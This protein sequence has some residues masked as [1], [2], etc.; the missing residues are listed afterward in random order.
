MTPR[1]RTFLLLAT[2]A[3]TA[4]GPAACTS[5]AGGEEIAADDAAFAEAANQLADEVR[6][7]G[8]STEDLAQLTA[9][10]DARVAD[11][12]ARKAAA[13]EQAARD[14][15]AYT[16]QQW[17]RSWFTLEEKKQAVSARSKDI[18]DRPDRRALAGAHAQQAIV[19]E[20]T[21][22]AGS[23][24]AGSVEAPSERAAYLRE[25]YVEIA[26]S[27]ALNGELG[28]ASQGGAR[29]MHFLRQKLPWLGKIFKGLRRDRRAEGIEGEAVNID[30]YAPGPELWRRNPS[31]STVWRPR[32]AEEIAPMRLFS[33]PWF[34]GA[35]PR[36]PRSGEV[37]KL[38]GFRS[39]KSDGS[40]PSIDLAHGDDQL[41]V[42]FRRGAGG[43]WE[44]APFSR[45]LWAMGYETD[46]IYNFSD[47]PMEPRAFLAAHAAVARVG[48]KIGPESDETIPGRPPRGFSFALS[49]IGD[50]PGPGNVV[51][52]FKDGREEGGAGAIETLKKAMDDRA[53]MDSMEVVVVK[54]VYG[55]V[56]RPGDLDS[57]GPW[58]FDA[59]NHVDDR[60]VRA[61]GVI[62]LGWLA[63]KDVKFNNVRLDTLTPKN[64]PTALF[65][66]LSDVG[67]FHS[68]L[69]DRV[70]I[71]PDGRFLHPDTNSYTIRAFDRLT[72]ND[73]KWAVARIGALTE[74]QIVACLATGTLSD[75]MLADYTERMVARRDDLVKTF[76]LGNE[77]GL[78]RPEGRPATIVPRHFP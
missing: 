50:S 45:L 61:L 53:L 66:T 44:D 65:H 68:D 54:R 29:I 47:F 31:S 32:S 7:L 41:K 21:D 16:P 19:R 22:L 73:A 30:R 39:Q 28:L 40:H 48:L 67:S 49:G 46:A 38:D 70:G 35:P 17:E 27:V 9:I 59:D 55:E 64:G 77:L 72:T 8:G 62:M 36:M 13:K 1:P 2:L 42:K 57:I 75:E 25:G 10:V 60:E 43:F 5:A 23:G 12:E 11:L 3:T 69:P 15:D 6:L 58:D 34:S 76:G 63:M 14:V 20:L 56:A 26:T 33:G 24:R 74:D 37:W 71:R 18:F 52:R 51:V 78:L 4:I